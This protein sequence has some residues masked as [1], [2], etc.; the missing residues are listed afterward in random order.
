MA[1]HVL[2]CEREQSVLCTAPSDEV[3][4]GVPQLSVAVAVPNAASM[5]AVEGL[6]PRVSELPFAMITGA[7]LSLYAKV[8]VLEKPFTLGVVPVTVVGPVYVLPFTVGAMVVIEKDVFFLAAKVKGVFCVSVTSGPDAGLYVIVKLPPCAHGGAVTVSPPV[9]GKTLNELLVPN[10]E[11]PFLVAVI[12]APVKA[13][14]IVTLT[15]PST[16]LVNA[17]LRPPPLVNV[18]LEVILTLLLLPLN[19]VAVL[20]KKSRAVNLMLNA[21]PSL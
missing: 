13:G 14:E 4:V 19:D 8:T 9:T 3:S 11:P 1:V 2:V 12:V 10:S 16:P 20:L 15:G 5:S 21:T 17:A 18:A 7:V 6:Q